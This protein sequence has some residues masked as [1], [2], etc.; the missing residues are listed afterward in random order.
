MNSRA[1][2]L[3]AMARDEHLCHK[4]D[5]KGESEEEESFDSGDVTTLAQLKQDLHLKRY[6]TASYSLNYKDF[7]RDLSSNDLNISNIEESIDTSQLIHLDD[8]NIVPNSF[9]S[10]FNDY[11]DKGNEIIAEIE[12]VASTS[13]NDNIVQNCLD[14][15]ATPIT[16]NDENHCIEPPQSNQ[17]ENQLEINN[18]GRPKRGRKRKVEDQPRKERKRRANVNE[19]YIS[20]KGKEV[21]PKE[22]DNTYHC[23]C[24][25]KC[26]TILSIESRKQAFDQ[27]WSLGSFE[28]RCAFICES[29]LKTQQRLYTLEDYAESI[30]KSK[31]TKKFEVSRMIPSDML[32]VKPLEQAIT[33][34][35]VDSAKKKVNWLKLHEILIE[36]PFPYIL[37]VKTEITQE[38]AQIVNLEK[39]GKGR[40]PVLKNINL[41]ECWP[42]G[43][44]LSVEK[45]KDLKE[46]MKLI[47][48]DAKPFYDFLKH[49]PGVSIDEDIDGYHVEDIE[50]L[51]EEGED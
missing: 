51:S 33:N 13:N 5:D 18:I 48:T 10:M 27:F 35:K 39:A 6:N 26:T 9:S 37:K 25:K 22:F 8:L 11:D 23:D 31:K 20:A 21:L 38:V 2:K 28:G 4:N 24:K 19:K 36:K 3:V 45:L 49:T 42:N 40:K 34:R 12:V 7:E 44:S 1:Q 14:M 43:K 30:Q 15:S 17:N 50:Q 41:P 47:P 46:L 16:E 32:S 29:Q